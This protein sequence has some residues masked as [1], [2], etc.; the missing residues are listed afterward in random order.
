MHSTKNSDTYQQG[1]KN[2]TR[3][4]IHYI[5]RETTQHIQ[6]AVLSYMIFID[7][8]NFWRM[9]V[10]SLHKTIWNTYN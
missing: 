5:R 1:Q 4:D 9:N 7:V 2:E 6:L 3:P 8:G 10:N